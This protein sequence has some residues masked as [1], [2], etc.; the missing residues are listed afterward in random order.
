MPSN[1]S[2]TAGQRA[3][4][5]STSWR[6]GSACVCDGALR[7][8]HIPGRPGLEP[9]PIRRGPSI[10]AMEWVAFAKRLP[11][12]MCPG[13]RRDDVWRGVSPCSRGTDASELS[14][15]AA[16]EMTEGAGKAGCPPHPWSACRKK[17]RGRTTGTGGS[18]G[19]PC[20]MALRLIRDLPGDHAWLPPSPVRRETHLHDLGACIGA[21]EPHDFA[22][23]CSIIRPRNDCA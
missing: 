9:G 8:S 23:R 19:L 4:R 2:P 7:C 21:P 5:I 15:R 3:A 20:A 10:E 13:L 6:A 1:P 18:S 16:L 11:M 14:D 12:V 17:A 22:V